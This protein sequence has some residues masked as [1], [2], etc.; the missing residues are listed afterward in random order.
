MNRRGNGLASHG[1]EKPNP[2]GRGDQKAEEQAKEP[3]EG[4]G[5]ERGGMAVQRT[6]KAPETCLKGLTKKQGDVRRPLNPHVT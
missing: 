4:Q 6:L 5:R 2:K 1:D 3:G